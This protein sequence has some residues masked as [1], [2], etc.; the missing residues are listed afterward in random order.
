MSNMVVN[1]NVLA[2]NSHRSM[3]L[4]GSAQSKA[5]ARLSSGI[6]I[7]SAADDAAGLAISEKMRAQIRG[8]E[9]ASKNSQD[10]ISLVQTAEGGMQEI[11]NMVQRI[12]ELVVQSSNDTNEHNPVGTG[13]RQKLQ[14]EVNQ[15]IAEIDSMAG[16]TE[17]NKKKLID[18][19]YAGSNDKIRL[20]TVAL[21][22]TTKAFD[23][24][25]KA[26]LQASNI[27]TAASDSFS[28]FTNSTNWQ[29]YSATNNG[30]YSVANAAYTNALASVT[31]TNVL[32]NLAND[33]GLN[34]AT[35]SVAASAITSTYAYSATNTTAGNTAVMTTLQ[36][37]GAT[38]TLTNTGSYPTSITA[39]GFTGTGTSLVT[40]TSAA[41]TSTATANSNYTAINTASGTSVFTGTNASDLAYEAAQAALLSGDNYKVQKANDYINAYNLAAARKLALDEVA[42][43]MNDRAKV[44]NNLSEIQRDATVD[45][46]ESIQARTDVDTEKINTKTKLD[47]EVAA[48]AGKDT[49][50]EGLYMQVGA[51]AD[52]GIFLT[53]GSLKSDAL[54]LKDSRGNIAINVLKG[55]GG[56]ITGLLD[57]LDTALS[58]VTSERSKLGALQNRMEYT[59]KS[60]DISAENLSASE[61][62]VR[63]T[64]MAKEMM[65]FTKT[66]VLQ[67]AAMS[68]L[69][70]ANQNPQNILQLLR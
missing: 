39:G 1:T 14:D 49:A 29:S 46:N 13:D 26:V 55:G 42:N 48:A 19:T 60:L 25:N 63:D 2:L 30:A 43:V 51:N 4:V 21:D 53:I 27:A 64:D 34:T 5:A 36:I 32:A 41:C 45:L 15:L 40:A 50:K 6:K 35:S 58:Y 31:A 54:G 57:R 3:K 22:A 11:D 62:R 12:R 56:D 23:K 70:Q 16:R 17:F 61:S 59:I 37:S 65:T 28:K 66:N 44:F 24:A 33:L 10:S 8:L 7:N 47:A 18:G 20:L 9:M 67:N 38:L 52:Q 69:T 68:M